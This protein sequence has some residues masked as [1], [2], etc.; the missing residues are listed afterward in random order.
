LGVTTSATNTSTHRAVV[1][2]SH[3]AEAPPFWPFLVRDGGI[4]TALFTGFFSAPKTSVGKAPE[5]TKNS[6][7]CFMVYTV[8]KPPFYCQI[9]DG[10]A[11][12]GSHLNLQD[13]LVETNKMLMFGSTSCFGVIPKSW[14]VDK[15]N[16]DFITALNHKN[17]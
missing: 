7:H 3:A 14:D 16:G 2:E 12:I 15:Q 10:I 13:K 17:I 5:T 9:G 4:F 1:A 6:T 11:N 8:E